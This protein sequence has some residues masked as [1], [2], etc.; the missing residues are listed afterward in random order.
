VN[1]EQ[2]WR[3]TYM[4]VVPPDT[5]EIISS[6]VPSPLQLNF[7]E[8]YSDEAA[9]AAISEADFALVATY[10]LPAS[11]IKSGRRLRMIQ[12]QGVGYDKTDV[13]FAKSHGIPVALCPEGTITGVA[14]HVFLLI[15]SIYKQILV[16]DL[17]VRRGEWRQFS[18]RADSFEIAG[19]KLG[20]LGLGRIGEAVARR[21]VSFEAEVNYFDIKRRTIDEERKFGITFKPFKELLKVSNIVSLHLPNSPETYHIM[22]SQSFDL[23]QAGSILINTARGELV[24]TQA[25][26]RALQIGHLGGAGLDVFELEPPDPKDPL[27]KLPNVV[28]TPHIA[29]G[30]RDALIEKMDACFANM[31]RVVQGESP[32]HIVEE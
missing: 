10:P 30:T 16:A 3:V 25:L 5:A 26:Q 13:K 9:I 29:A 15:L 2:K 12:H 24:D 1:S 6:R 27:L 22:N 21:A 8:D 7:I 19:K 4:E 23:M 18:L 14:E 20:I 28:L 31:L 32:W 17:S 11:V